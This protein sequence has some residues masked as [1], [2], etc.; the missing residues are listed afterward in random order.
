M[1]RSMSGMQINGI[2][3]MFAEHY[4]NLNIQISQLLDV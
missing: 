3:A 1:V 4:G 2:D